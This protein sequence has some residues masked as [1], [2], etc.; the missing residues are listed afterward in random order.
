VACAES[1]GHIMKK[2][3]AGDEKAYFQR[4]QPYLD[5]LDQIEIK[6]GSMEAPRREAYTAY[7]TRMVY[8]TTHTTERFS[9]YD[10]KCSG[11][12]SEIKRAN[13]K[14][15]GRKGRVRGRSTGR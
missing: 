5:E 13:Q 12:E 7:F 11:L 9:L 8:R 15:L 14:N 4:L 3:K 10:V 6:I 2:R 1:S